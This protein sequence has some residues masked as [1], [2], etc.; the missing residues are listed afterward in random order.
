MDLKLAE[1]YYFAFMLSLPRMYAAFAVMTFLSKQVVT[2]TLI[3]NG[4][5][6]SLA[7]FLLPI[8][9]HNLGGFKALSSAQMTIIIAKE[10]ALG[11]LVGYIANMPL[12]AIT[13]IGEMIDNQRGATIM[14][15]LNFLTSSQ[16]S[17]LGNVLNQAGV[18]IFMISG[19]F[20]LFFKGMVVSYTAW[21]VQTFL[22]TFDMEMVHYFVGQF[23]YLIEMIC[24]LGG[25]VIVVLYL[26]DIGLALMSRFAPQLN[27]FIL[28][29]SIKSALALAIL[30]VYFTVIVDFFQGMFLHIDET[31][32]QIFGLMQ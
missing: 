32:G 14:E 13:A 18:T 23:Q 2:G 1:S 22:P 24:L 25:P 19:A 15:S 21:P 9:D 30:A 10:I 11:F 4:L 5:V 16:G 6:L 27:V 8:L 29:L 26:S 17:P 3:R 31:V 28:S 12:W 20:L 7:L